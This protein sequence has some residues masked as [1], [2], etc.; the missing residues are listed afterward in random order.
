MLNIV[1][2]EPNTDKALYE[3]TAKDIFR[4]KLIASPRKIQ[5]YLFEKKSGSLSF[6]PKNENILGIVC[7]GKN[8]DLPG[9]Y[10]VAG[11][12]PRLLVEMDSYDEKEYVEIWTSS[13]D[14]FYG[15][16]NE[17][18]FAMDGENLF[19]CSNVGYLNYDIATI[20]EKLYDSL[21]NMIYS[22]NYPYIYRMWNFVPHI[23]RE[24]KDYLE[25]YKAFCYG[26]A[27]SFMKNN[28]FNDEVQ[29]PAAT[30][31]GTLQGIIS[32][33]FLST[34]LPRSIHIENPRQQPA[35]RYPHQ[36]GPKPPSFARAT[37]MDRGI[38]GHSIYISGTASVIG[39]E[40]KYLNNIEKQCTTTLENIAILVSAE[41]LDRYNINRRDG[42]EDIK[43]IRAYVRKDE[44]FP[45]V[46]AMCEN[47]FPEQCS[48]VFQKA[49]VC[50]AE[51][52]VEIEG[53]IF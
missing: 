37:Y 24:G 13:G 40:S 12:V 2:A 1:E 11:Q 46:K 43:L 9:H 29:F 44:D 42:I 28:S 27:T 34:A 33:Y 25:R 47:W 17:W 53:I 6:L 26:R 50:R 39:H 49:D 14:V 19:A 23:N 21:F 15:Q 38:H 5:T 45:I 41:N 35:Y 18:F 30:G 20:G 8:A 3:E 51:L 16:T 22:M 52:Q 4:N 48:F 32:V 7:Y 31:I 10:N 36:Y